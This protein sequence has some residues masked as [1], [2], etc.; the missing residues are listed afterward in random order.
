[1]QLKK[2]YS[3]F[4]IIVRS[5]TTGKMLALNVNQATTIAEIK[6]E[7]TDREGVPAA[8]LKVVIAGK[9]VEDGT[10]LSTFSLHERKGPVTL[11]LMLRGGRRN[12]RKNRKNTR[13]NRKNRKGTRRN[14]YY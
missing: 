13:K 2:G 12:T 7:I 1:M 11:P 5:P 6:Q 10:T 8:E 4:Q 9:E 3:P 14:N